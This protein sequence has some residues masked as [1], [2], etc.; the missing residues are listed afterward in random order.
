MLFRKPK[1]MSVGKC[2]TEQS[3]R[4]LRKLL[5]FFDISFFSFKVTGDIFLP[6]DS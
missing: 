1:S 3:S 4:L 5:T 6:D 2:K